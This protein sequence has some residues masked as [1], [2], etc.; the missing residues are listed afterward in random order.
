MHDPD[1]LYLYVTDGGHWENTGLVELIRDR[2]ID[3]VV[4]LDA[5]EKPRETATRSPAIGL[6]KLECNADIRSTWTHCAD[7]TTDV[8]APTTP[9]SPSRSDVIRRGDH[10]ACSGTRNRC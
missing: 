8:G 2:T 10:R 1:D 7:R 5:D 6:A 9:R 3:E 4:C